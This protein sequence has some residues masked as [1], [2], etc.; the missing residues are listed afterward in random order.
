[1]TDKQNEVELLPEEWRHVVG[2]EGYYEISN[3]GRVRSV[4][5]DIPSGE[6]RRILHGKP[7]KPNMKKGYCAVVLTAYHRR[8]HVWIHRLVA[9]AFI[10]NPDNL[11]QVNHKD[12]NRS[13]NYVE[14]LEWCTSKYNVNYGT[15]RQRM[16]ATSRLTHTSCKRVAIFDS[17][18]DIM[19]V[20]T[21]GRESARQLGVSKSYVSGVCLDMYDNPTLT[22]RYVPTP[23]LPGKE[24]M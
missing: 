18:G 12:E 24:G 14:N 10:P 21:S 23:P 16:S 19:Q 9:Q 15:G 20:F 6:H 22:L 2:Y 1:M 11:P 3:H 17:N 5:R 13:N 4:H 7:I 8:K